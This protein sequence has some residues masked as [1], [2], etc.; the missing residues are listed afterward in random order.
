MGKSHFATTLRHFLKGL[1]PWRG[2]V[3]IDDALWQATLAQ[4][5]F[6]QRLS[7][8]QR[9]RLR[10]LAAQFLAQKQFYGAGGLEV[11]P[12]MA[13]AVAAQACV[14]LLHRAGTPAQ[15]LRCW[16]RSVDVVLY[17][18]DVLVPHR[19][20]DA[21]GVEHA[22]V[23]AVCGQAMD[24]G[25]V[26]L[27]WAA[28]LEAAGA[29]AGGALEPNLGKNSLLTCP[30][31]G[32]GGAA[33]VPKTAPTRGAFNVVIHEFAHQLDM[34]AAAGGNGSPALPA[35]W[36][37]CTSAAAARGRWAQTWRSAWDDF[38]EAL[39]AHEHFGQAAPSVLDAYAASAPAEFFAVACEG[40]WM[41]YVDFQQA[42]PTLCEALDALFFPP[43]MENGWR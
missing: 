29:D 19:V 1:R 17:P 6:L 7:A 11:S 42:Y 31:S 3:Q 9:A 22:F 41:Q 34:A 40:Y 30:G 5:D 37:G 13:L 35:G 21:A 32:D 25:P 28:V 36:L 10:R 8:A 15:A 4:F 14:L 12:A 39:A 27:S 2:G 33:Q 38:R 26:V 43:H 24:G 23:Q 16:A 20:V 18:D